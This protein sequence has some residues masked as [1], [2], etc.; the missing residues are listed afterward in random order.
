MLP[1]LSAGLDFVMGE[2]R[3]WPPAARLLDYFTEVC[4]LGELPAL[5]SVWLRAHDDALPV[6]GGLL[7]RR[8]GGDA[9]GLSVKVHAATLDG[10]LRAAAEDFAQRHAD[11][12]G[13]SVQRGHQ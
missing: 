4:R 12:P 13:A 1:L 8:S 9:D 2:L 7:A 5:R 6:P 11:D 3:H 10:T